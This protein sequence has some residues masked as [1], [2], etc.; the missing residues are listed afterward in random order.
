MIHSPFL[1][2]I[3]TQLS[4]TTELCQLL[5][6]T[7]QWTLH[8][9]LH[10]T[11]YTILYIV[12]ITAHCTVYY[13]IRYNS[14]CK[15][16][17]TA[18]LSLHCSDFLLQKPKSGFNTVRLPCEKSGITTPAGHI[19]FGFWSLKSDQQWKS[20]RNCLEICPR[21]VPWLIRLS[22]GAAPLG[23]VWFPLGLP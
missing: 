16:Y 20:L 5:H 21:E 23:K 14:N 1:S 9:I 6:W 18:H 2:M 19:L 17:C 12:H 22:L 8:C 10:H 11:L 3:H 7:V 4:Q 13:A 15:V